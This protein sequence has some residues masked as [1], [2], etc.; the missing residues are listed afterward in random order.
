MKTINDI[1]TEVF[2]SQKKFLLYV[3]TVEKIIELNDREDLDVALG[4]L[5]AEFYKMDR[6][7]NT[8]YEKTGVNLDSGMKDEFYKLKSRLELRYGKLQTSQ[9]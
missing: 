6:L 7:V 4:Y 5:D 2:E 3:S 9:V 1:A 8:F